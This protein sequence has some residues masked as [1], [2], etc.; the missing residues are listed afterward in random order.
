VWAASRCNDLTGTPGYVRRAG[1]PR[2]FA[3]PA[4][5]TGE[6]RAGDRDERPRVADGRLHPRPLAGRAEADAQPRPAPRVLP[7]HDPRG[8]QGHRA[9]RLRHLRGAARRLRQHTQGRGHR[10]EELLL[11]APPRSDVPAH[12][13]DGAARRLR[14]HHQPAAVV[15]PDARILPFDI[16]YNRRRAVRQPGHPG[17]RHPR[18]RCPTSTAGA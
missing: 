5:D 14:P 8:R 6:G 12:R 4:A 15:A 10:H 11:R 3:R 17:I 16:F 9:A 2:G 13:E 7:A 1:T 18:S